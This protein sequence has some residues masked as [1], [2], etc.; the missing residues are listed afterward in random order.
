MS[1]NLDCTRRQFLKLAGTAAAVATV[2]VAA[3][4]FVS[5]AQA[6]ELDLVSK[7]QTGVYA[8][9]ANPKLY[10][11]RKSQENPMV[12]KLYAKDG[13]LNDGPAGH[14]AHK[15]LHTHF[16]DRSASVKALKAK[17][18]KLKA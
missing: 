13:F 12:Q 14:K 10:K 2:A 11:L 7:R 15:L 4:S 5:E 17:G 9:D 3:P 18:I 6:A 1:N 8:A 16:V